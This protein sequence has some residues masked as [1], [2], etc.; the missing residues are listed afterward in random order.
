MKPTDKH[1]KLGFK[2]AQG[3]HVPKQI[4]YS[5]LCENISLHLNPK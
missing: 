5:F 4:N 2:G 3:I 1:S